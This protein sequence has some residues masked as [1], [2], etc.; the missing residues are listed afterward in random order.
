MKSVWLTYSWDDNREG[1]VDFIAQELIRVGLDVKLDKWNLSAG[2]FLWD[3]IFYFIQDSKT[4]G[5]L[6]YTTQSGLG[7]QACMRELE[8]ALDRALQTRGKEFPIIALFPASTDMN[9]IPVCTKERLCVSL[10]DFQW[11]E[12]VLASIEKR[13]PNIPK[14]QIFPF[15]FTVH[16]PHQKENYSYVIELRP[17]GGT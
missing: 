6:F 4:D 11:N 15:A 14:I 12:R 8:Y 7:S 17:R 2:K 13:I 10:K 9:L 16:T 1:D 3:Q 5:W